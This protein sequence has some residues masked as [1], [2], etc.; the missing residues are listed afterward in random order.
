[1]NDN[2]SH[3]PKHR[4]PGSDA[5][6]HREPAAIR[7]IVTNCDELKDAI[8]TTNPQTERE[9]NYYINKAHEFGCLHNIPPSWYQDDR[10]FT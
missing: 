6:K 8:K 5:G 9:R 1:M 2:I 7:F 3:L 10:P 4:R